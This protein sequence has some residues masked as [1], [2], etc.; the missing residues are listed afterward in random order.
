MINPQGIIPD[1]AWNDKG[2]NR[3]IREKRERGF[4]P[5]ALFAYF[6][7]KGV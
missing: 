6:A 7:V 3:E 1:Q 4:A 2:I 5:F